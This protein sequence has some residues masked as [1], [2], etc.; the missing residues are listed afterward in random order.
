MDTS[1]YEPLST[2]REQL[3][4]KHIELLNERVHELETNLS[5]RSTRDAEHR[6]QCSSSYMVLP[7]TFTPE[8]ECSPRLEI[9]SYS[10]SDDTEAPL[11][12]IEQANTRVY[13]TIV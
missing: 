6:E 1:D 4:E 10:P 3:L 12:L 13:E 2:T 7:V 8:R 5:L 11:L 9:V